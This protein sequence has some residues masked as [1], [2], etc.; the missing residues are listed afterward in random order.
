MITGR[1]IH[2]RAMR[3]SHSSLRQVR[4]GPR[5]R[6]LLLCRPCLGSSPD[7]ISQRQRLCLRDH[8]PGIWI[9]DHIVVLGTRR[10]LRR[11]DRITPLRR[12][13]GA[14][15]LRSLSRARPRQ[16]TPKPRYPR[17]RGRWRSKSYPRRIRE[18]NR[19]LAFRPFRIVMHKVWPWRRR[20]RHDGI[21]GSDIR[22]ISLS[23]SAEPWPS[24]VLRLLRRCPHRRRHYPQ[25]LRLRALLLGRFH[26][27][28]HTDALWNSRHRWRR[29]V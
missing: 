21:R 18:I 19:R 28:T 8:P 29:F 7:L 14:P 12:H 10:R 22:Q 13:C 16:G 9:V 23:R 27:D 17:S 1:P 26:I 6:L 25:A 15:P 4:T 24:V 2:R 3:P 11:P 20:R 5:W